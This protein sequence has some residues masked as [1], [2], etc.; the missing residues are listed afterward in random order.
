MA[1]QIRMNLRPGLL[2]LALNLALI[3]QC[4]SRNNILWHV[5]TLLGNEMVNRLP[6]DEL[7]LLSVADL[8]KSGARLCNQLLVRARKTYFHTCAMTSFCINGVTCVRGCYAALRNDVTQ[9]VLMAL[10]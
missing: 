3:I 7:L 4:L 9:L 8:S 10:C 6:E 2:W 5:N 1:L